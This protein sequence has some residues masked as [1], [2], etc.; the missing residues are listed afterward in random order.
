M[1]NNFYVYTLSYPPEMGGAVFYVGKGCKS[2]IKNHLVQAQKGAQSEKCDIIRK[3]LNGRGKVI[4]NKVA[5]FDFEADAYEF[6]E[7]LIVS[8]GRDRLANCDHRVMGPR[9]GI[10]KWQMVGRSINPKGKYQLTK[11]VSVEL[12][13]AKV[14][15]VLDCGHA[16]SVS[17]SDDLG[18]P[19]DMFFRSTKKRIGQWQRCIMC[20][21]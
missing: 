5:V 13:D 3:I 11:I 10:A 14:E 18:E 21:L 7:Q 4:E 12:I 1:A 2:R 16:Y 6:E 15:I 9:T 17:S 20:P 8:I 19:M